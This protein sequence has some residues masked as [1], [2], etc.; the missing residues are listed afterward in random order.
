[1]DNKDLK[2][3]FIIPSYNRY[4][5]LTNLLDQI[6]KYDNTSVIVFNDASN[7]VR[8]KSLGNTYNN[9]T[10]IHNTKNN[11]KELYL[12]TVNTLI[13]NVEKTDTD[14]VI[15]LADDF[16]ICNNFTNI[17][18]N[19]VNEYSIINIFSI[20]QTNWGF[21]GWIDGA[22]VCSKSGLSVIKNNLTTTKV[23]GKGMSTGV[24]RGIT[25]YFNKNTTNG[26]KLITLNYSLTQ[27][28]GN[29]DSK[30]HPEHRLK[31]PITAKNYYNDFYGQKIIQ[32]GDSTM[33]PVIKK[34]NS[35]D[36]SGSKVKPKE[37][38]K[39]TKPIINSPVTTEKVKPTKP[40]INSPITTE[41]ANL[42]KEEPPKNMQKPKGINKI[43]SDVFMG[44]S[45]KK[46][47]RFGKK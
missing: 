43:H 6:S 30:L 25:Q 9:L 23:G 26:Y 27:H 44:K 31:T 41:K 39:P 20:H 47:L 34:K 38:V 19:I 42:K 3:T 16:I 5:K 21:H 17:L 28:D 35:G 11:G 33:T 4:D 29:E 18:T 45:M 36:I 14:Y 12:N 10:I 22:F 46:K 24:W 1:M 7:D 32:I 2:F 8:Y 37:N 13:N 40:T 15:M